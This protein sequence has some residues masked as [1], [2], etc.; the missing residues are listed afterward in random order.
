MSAASQSIKAGSSNRQ[1]NFAVFA[2]VLAMA[3][4]VIV[5]F[6]QLSASRLAIAPAAAPAPV[7]HDHGWSSADNQPLVLHDRGWSSA[8]ESFDGTLGWA[9]APNSAAI[10]AAR[11]PARTSVTMT[12]Y[13]I[14]VQAP[15][16]GI[17]YNGIPNVR[18][19]DKVQIPGGATVYVDVPASD[20]VLSQAGS[21]RGPRAKAE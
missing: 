4:L 7:V 6:G 12:P 15:R 2:L 19:G 14:S 20:L 8:S 17:L 16:G 5:G 3:A 21:A 18:A 10:D 13:G 9:T 1:F 11:H